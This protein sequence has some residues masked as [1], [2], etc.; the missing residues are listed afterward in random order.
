MEV[1]RRESGFTLIEML[2]VMIIIS[3]LASIAMGK[4]K[5]TKDQAY[6]A[7][8]M[9]DIHTLTI[10]Q[11]SYLVDNN[12]YYGGVVPDP[13]FP[14]RAASGVTTTLTNGSAAGWS[15]L[16]THQNSTTTCG[17]FVGGVPPQAP[18]TAAGVAVCQRTTGGQSQTGP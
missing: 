6:E 1:L 15:A 7:T 14:F 18:A 3:T 12:T 17:V 10:A 4:F 2:T 5:G 8:M 9:A 13:N 11:E 16:L